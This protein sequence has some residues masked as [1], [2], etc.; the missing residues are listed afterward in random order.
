MILLLKTI[1]I[2][3][4]KVFNKQ[5]KLYNLLLQLTVDGV[6]TEIGQIV[7]PNVEREQKPEPGL[8]QTQLQLMAVQI[9][10]GRQQ[11]LR[12]ATLNLVLVNNI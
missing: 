2:A 3:V 8:V 6:I 1:L 7:Q 9:V 10:L 4:Q 5:K 11:K 12:T